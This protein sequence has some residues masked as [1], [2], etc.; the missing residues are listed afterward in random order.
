M[1]KMKGRGATIVVLTAIVCLAIESG[2]S[3]RQEVTIGMAG[4][5]H[6]DINLELAPVFVYYILDLA[7]AFSEAENPEDIDIFEKKEI[8]KQVEARPGTAVER[9]ETPSQEKLR[10]SFSYNDVRKLFVTEDATPAILSFSVQDGVR[11]VRFY[12]DKQNYGLVAKLFPMLGTPV[13]ENLAPQV[14]ETIPLA[15]YIDIIE[16]AMGEE[17]V[18][19]LQ[20]SFINIMV[21]VPGTIV[22]QR[23][24]TVRDGGVFFSI[25]LS[26]IALLNE[27]L[28]FEIRYR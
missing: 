21:K 25:P 13:F 9:I 14:E 3:V 26:R 18:D 24:G 7:E 20:S 11:R 27:P 2:C 28:D 1:E 19:A 5:G 6:T 17:G 23:G 22:S 4:E 8:R 15:E 12:L 16:F 10:L